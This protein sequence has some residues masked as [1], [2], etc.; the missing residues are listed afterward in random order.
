VD[1]TTFITTGQDSDGREV[2]FYVT[3]ECEKES[4]DFAIFRQLKAKL[5]NLADSGSSP[6]RYDAFPGAFF[7][8]RHENFRIV[9][10]TREKKDGTPVLCHVLLRVLKRGDKD[11]D[12]FKDGKTK[13]NRR[14]TIV[15][16]TNV[17]WEEVWTR[18][19][20]VRSNPEK[21]RSK[22]N[23]LS[24]AEQS[25]LEDRRITHEIFEIPVYESIEWVQSMRKPEFNDYDKVAE[26]LWNYIT[27]EVGIQDFAAGL[28][29]KPYGVHN[30]KCLFYQFSYGGKHAFFLLGLGPDDEVQRCRNLWHKRVQGIDLNTSGGAEFVA[31]M[32]RRAYPASELADTDSW[33]K[34]EQEKRSNF[35]LSNQEMDILSGTFSFPLFIDGRAGSG[36]STVLQYL[37]ADYLLRH[38]AHPEVAPPLYLSHSPDL[39][40]SAMSLAEVLF[41]TNVSYVKER[42]RIKRTI[43]DIK[44]SFQGTQ[45][46]FGTFIVFQDLMRKFIGDQEILSRHFAQSKRIEY[47]E[48]HKRWLKEFGRTRDAHKKYGPAI[49]W[50]IIRSYIKGWDY[51]NYFEPEQYKNIGSK[52][53][54]VSDEAYQL[55]FQ[56]VWK[57]WYQPLRVEQGYWDD[58]DLVRYCLAP[59]D[60][61]PMDSYVKPIFSAVFCDESQDFTRVELEFILRSSIFSERN[62][63]EHQINKIPFVFAGDEFQT[64]NP[65]GFSW[66]MLRSYFMERL[67]RTL[68]TKRGPDDPVTL[69]KNFRSTEPIIKLGN[70]LLLLRQVRFEGYDFVPQTPHFAEQEA[71]SVFCLSPDEAEVWKKMKEVEV[72]LIVPCENGETPREYVEN[73]PIKE[74]IEFND[75]GTAQKITFVNPTQ[76][77]GLEYPNVAVYGFGNNK[78]LLPSK[79]REFFASNKTS[80][81][82]QDVDQ[83]YFLNNVYVSI[84]RAQQQLF[85]IDRMVNTVDKERSFWEFAFDDPQEPRTRKYVEEIEEQMLT[86]AGDRSKW[87]SDDL[88][89]IISGTVSDI[90]GDVSDPIERAGIIEKL[91]KSLRDADVMR[92][93]A[94]RYRERGKKEM[95]REC[96]AFADEFDEKYLLAGEK[97][98]EIRLYDHAIRC[99]WLAGSKESDRN[100]GMKELDGLKKHR[101]KG[102]EV[103]VATLYQKQTEDQKQ[104]DI[105]KLKTI[106]QAVCDILSGADP[107]RKPDEIY[108]SAVQWQATLNSLLSRVP[109][110]LIGSMNMRVILDL[111]DKLAELELPLD[112]DIQA[113]WYFHLNNITKALELWDKLN[114][115]PGRQVKNENYHKAKVKNV[116][117]PGNLEFWKNIHNWEEGVIEEY[118]Q[119]PDKSLSSE[120]HSTVAEAVLKYGK[121]DEIRRFLPKLLADKTHFSN[122]KRDIDTA[123]R[124]DNTIPSHF[125]ETLVRCKLREQVPPSMLTELQKTPQTSELLQMI[126][127]LMEVRSPKFHAYLDKSFGIDDKKVIDVMG[128]KFKSFPRTIWN[129]PLLT[130]VGS[131]FEKRGHFLN[132]LRYYE[133]ADAQTDDREFKKD[134]ALRWIACKEKQ[135][136]KQID[137]AKLR[138]NYDEARKKRRDVGLGPDD[139]I[140]EEPVFT[141]WTNLFNE[142]LSFTT[143]REEQKLENE[144]SV[145]AQ[146]VSVP[147]STQPQQTQD[148]SMNFFGYSFRFNPTKFELRIVVQIEEEGLSG[149][150]RDGR[151][152]DDDDFIIVEGR[153]LKKI[154]GV[155][156]VFSIIVSDSELILIHDA[157]GVQI[158]F[159]KSR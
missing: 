8:I 155:P 158:H 58:Q 16:L 99:F 142:I 54:T 141:R 156:T 75:D 93:A 78:D 56:K 18:I 66:S 111:C 135:A 68:G 64:L 119:A 136:D 5:E 90:S 82:D 49:S 110:H 33:R 22:K 112:L 62:I 145:E 67:M 42:Q 14:N 108:S 7:R 81:S 116:P 12:D 1:D 17:N 37:F 101:S 57:E 109:I 154:S 76:A 13:E 40:K 77:K 122:A 117:Y 113:E 149:T 105:G 35:H 69:T 128:E 51:N 26:T 15:R 11:Y 55:V 23:N 83:K 131:I 27:E 91:G 71:A 3:T 10:T 151:F 129:Q 133:W 39:I 144:F 80:S 31:G 126:T 139:K 19:G 137:H 52:N 36:K 114:K 115:M 100:A 65:T 125:L 46:T 124:R 44:Q 50:H 132:A 118:R 94:A 72:V 123:L 121:S 74:Y 28:V 95:A 147:M 104:T 97:F 88:G 107:V 157:S 41:D 45:G 84:T 134:L 9:G 6:R 25:F 89:R 59:D 2:R 152:S 127:A 138:E 87:S 38:C 96:E 92:Q 4:K 63:Y 60:D 150:I 20:Q 30:E 73:S 140:A 143:I 98:K 159:P 148:F 47:A 24:E 103:Q 61:D 85:I 70:R 146:S 120:Q 153:L 34:M 43:D 106:M 130:E 48:F 102:L 21:F 79:L 32:C 53:R 86:R 29:E